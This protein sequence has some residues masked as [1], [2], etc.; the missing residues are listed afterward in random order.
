MISTELVS[1]ST[2]GRRSATSISTWMLLEL[3]E[4]DFPEVKFEPVGRKYWNEGPGSYN[5]VS[6]TLPLTRYPGFDFVQQ[7]CVEDDER[8]GTLLT[9]ANKYGKYAITEQD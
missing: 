6:T 2:S 7:L 9:V 4:N 5:L 3:V 1:T 8:A